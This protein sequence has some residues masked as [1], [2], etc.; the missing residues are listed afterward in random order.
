MGESL[1]VRARYCCL[2]PQRHR[3]TEV[4][5]EEGRGTQMNADQKG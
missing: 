4:H 1:L 3:A 2:E 5:R